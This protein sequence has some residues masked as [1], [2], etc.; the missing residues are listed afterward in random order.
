MTFSNNPEKLS[1]FGGGCNE[2]DRILDLYGGLSRPEVRSLMHTPRLA[3]MICRLFQLEKALPS[4]QTGVYQSAILA[5]LQETTEREMEEIP[6]SILDDLAPPALQESVEKLCKL[7]YEGL[8][9]KKVVFKKSEL[10][11]AG[12]LGTFHPL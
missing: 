6:H 4:T 11:A 9:S 8:A 1:L 12:C 5:M 10:R 3:T 7:A 2:N